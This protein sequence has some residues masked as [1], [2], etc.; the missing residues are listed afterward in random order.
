M[1]K[2]Y[3]HETTKV[4]YYSGVKLNEDRHCGFVF[5]RDCGATKPREFNDVIE[6]TRYALSLIP[7][8]FCHG[9]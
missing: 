9:Q 7:F 5:K 4:M 1:E 8:P 3:S 6:N 2:M